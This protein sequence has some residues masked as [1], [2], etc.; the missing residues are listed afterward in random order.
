MTYHNRENRNA[1]NKFARPNPL[2]GEPPTGEL[3]VSPNVPRSAT[4]LAIGVVVGVLFAWFNE[5]QTQVPCP[6]PEYVLPSGATFNAE[7]LST[8]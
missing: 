7:E 2:P 8:P 6:E 3:D 1:R 5:Y 4:F